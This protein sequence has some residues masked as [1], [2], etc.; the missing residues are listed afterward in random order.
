MWATT[1]QILVASCAS[2]GDPRF[3]RQIFR[4]L[5]SVSHKHGRGIKVSAIGLTELPNV[6]SDPA[7]SSIGLQN[8]MGLRLPLPRRVAL[9]FEGPASSLQIL[10][11][12]LCNAQGKC[13]MI[14][15]L[16]VSSDGL[17][18]LQE[19]DAKGDDTTWRVCNSSLS[20][21][22]EGT[23]VRLYDTTPYV[24]APPTATGAD[25]MKNLRLQASEA[26]P[27]NFA[28]NGVGGVQLEG[29]PREID[30]INCTFTVWACT[31]SSGCCRV[32]EDG[33][34]SEALVCEF[35]PKG[36]KEGLKSMLPGETRRFWIPAE[37]TD[38]RF[39][40]PPPDRYLPVGSLVVDMTLHSI[41]REAVFTY[42]MSDEAAKFS[43][44]RELQPGRL[45][46]RAIGV[47][48]QFLPL[49]WYLQQQ[50]QQQQAGDTLGLM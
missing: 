34:D 43:T 18:E 8:R 14:E 2:R 47:G 28:Y 5:A 41:T 27:G 39:G 40:R 50:Q 1:G 31:D 38:R 25:G 20:S 35:G 24:E 3:L 16:G 10:E 22:P 29:Y 11:A 32:V 30:G 33:E 12:S 26:D 21:L 19:T 42:N 49:A 44:E 36:I 37:I 17:V 9:Q 48:V 45:L 4:P 6:A 7:L 15:V 23:C 13:M 46:L